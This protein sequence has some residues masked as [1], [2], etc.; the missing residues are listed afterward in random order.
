MW[1]ID[2]W[3]STHFPVRPD[4]DG[5]VRYQIDMPDPVAA[6]LA[7]CQMTANHRGWTPVRSVILY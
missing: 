7:A 3:F 1:T 5:W 6:E 4:G 2:V